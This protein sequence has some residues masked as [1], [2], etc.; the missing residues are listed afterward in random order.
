LMFS[1][2]KTSSCHLDTK[3]KNYDGC[4]L[5]ITRRYLILENSYT[6]FTKYS[7]FCYTTN[8]DQ[9]INWSFS[10]VLVIPQLSDP[11]VWW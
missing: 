8:N 1:I 2:T 4:F 7:F 9:P 11:G 6:Q 3:W 10:A 5:L